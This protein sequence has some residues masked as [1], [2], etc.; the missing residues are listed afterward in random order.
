MRFT[1][2]VSLMQ[3]VVF[4]MLVP[5]TGSDCVGSCAAGGSL[6]HAQR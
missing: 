2:P 3:L 1:N 5:G 6:I 4:C